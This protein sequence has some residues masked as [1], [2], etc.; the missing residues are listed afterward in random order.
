MANLEQLESGGHTHA[1]AFDSKKV[2]KEIV[3]I[4]IYLSILTI[5]ELAMGFIMMDWPEQSLKRHLMK[6]AIMVLML[7]K[8]FYIIAYFMHL[9]HEVRNMIMA[10]VIPA[11]LFVWFIPAFLGDGESFKNLRARMD[12]YHVERTQLPMEFPAEGHHGT[13]EAPETHKMEVP[14]ATPATEDAQ[15]A[16][17]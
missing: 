2:R 6:G 17:H 5:A 11:V 4:T 16:G 8:A 3:K 9:R 10:I 13:H 1:H 12:P 15:E 7:W 14:A